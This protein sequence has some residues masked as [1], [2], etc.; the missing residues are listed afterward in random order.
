MWEYC[1]K[2]WYKTGFTCPVEAGDGA[3]LKYDDGQAC[4]SPTLVGMQGSSIA[5]ELGRLTFL[6]ADG[7]I[8]TMLV[9]NMNK[10]PVSS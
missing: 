2:S 5:G 10:M 4:G 1:D 7:N 8:L 6:S 3:L 9:Q